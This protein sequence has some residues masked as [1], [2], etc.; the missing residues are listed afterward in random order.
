MNKRWNKRTVLKWELKLS[1]FIQ[2]HVVG[3]S[4][5]KMNASYWRLAYADDNNLPLHTKRVIFLTFSC[6]NFKQHLK[7]TFFKKG[8]YKHLNNYNAFLREAR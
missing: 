4:V 8:Q 6:T 7:Y 3:F 5:N 1:Y 2:C